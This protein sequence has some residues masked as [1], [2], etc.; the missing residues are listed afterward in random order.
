MSIVIAILVV[1]VVVG[2]V[3]KFYPKKQL[4]FLAPGETLTPE[5]EVIAEPEV[6]NPPIVTIEP[7][8]EAAKM[9][10]KPKKKQAKKVDA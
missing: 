10:A 9:N 2:F 1:L 3:F 7:S 4:P 8:Q 6:V 5:P